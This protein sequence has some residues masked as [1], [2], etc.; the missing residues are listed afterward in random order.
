MIPR[1]NFRPHKF[2]KFP[3]GGM[4]TDPPRYSMQMCTQLEIWKP[5]IKIRG[6][7]HDSYQQVH[8]K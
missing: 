4:P 5:V 8:E 2:Q 7:A 1:F 6:A 3:Q